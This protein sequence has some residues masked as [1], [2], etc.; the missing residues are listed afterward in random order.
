[1]GFTIR[2]KGNEYL[3]TFPYSPERVCAIKS[4]GRPVFHAE[5]KT[6]RLPCQEMVRNK[7]QELAKTDQVIWLDK[8]GKGATVQQRV[9]DDASQPDNPLKPAPTDRM[10]FPEKVAGLPPAHEAAFQRYRQELVLS[11]YS[12]KT[13]K[14]YEGHVRRFLGTLPAERKPNADD[15]RSY[16]ETMMER[17]GLSHSFANQFICAMAFFSKRLLG[18]SLDNMPRPKKEDKLPQVLSQGEISRIFEQVENLKHRAMLFMVYASGLRVS[19]VVHLQVADIDGERMMIRIRQAKGR[20]DRYVMLSEKVRDILR[21]Y[22]RAYHP[23]EWLFPGQMGADVPITERTAQHVFEHARDKAGIRKKV[24][25]H[26]LRHSFATHLLEA[27]TDLRYIQELLGHAS[28]KATEIY[29]HVSKRNI[30]NIK[31]PLDSM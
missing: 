16:V 17:D 13:H 25:I 30:A 7:L 18:A 23:K 11:G 9:F 15:I 14:A 6:W 31:S 24:G 1:M 29:T 5:D 4:M 19:E 22:Y 10:V 26:V 3:V 8:D 20:K 12:P 27:G 28:S 21:S 2:R